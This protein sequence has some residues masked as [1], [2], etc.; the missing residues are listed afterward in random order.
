METLEYQS[1]MQMRTVVCIHGYPE[2]QLRHW[3][4]TQFINDRVLGL[5]G[6]Y[7]LSKHAGS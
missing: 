7:V 2:H 5:L 4:Q 3:L 6:H 1:G